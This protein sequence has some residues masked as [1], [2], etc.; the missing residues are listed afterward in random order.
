MRLL[1]LID[2]SWTMMLLPKT[3]SLGAFNQGWEPQPG[4]K[5]GWWGLAG[6]KANQRPLTRKSPWG[7]A[8]HNC[9]IHTTKTY[10][11]QYSSIQTSC[12]YLLQQHGT[13][14]L[15]N[16]SSRA[17]LVRVYLKHIHSFS[18]EVDFMM[19]SMTLILKAE[20]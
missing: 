13:L 1:Q 14:L 18:V 2:K 15:A 17:F 11:C 20:C 6:Q 9:S 19:I 12:Q 16:L 4:A 3:H 5:G 8:I 7:G 10:S